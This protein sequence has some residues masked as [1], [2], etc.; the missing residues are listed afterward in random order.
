MKKGKGTK[1]SPTVAIQTLVDAFASYVLLANA[2]MEA[3]KGA[4]ARRYDKK[5]HKLWTTLRDDF[6]Q[7]GIDALARLLQDNRR[8]IRIMAAVHL[9]RHRTDDC[10]HLLK[11]EAGGRGLIA[12]QAEQTVKT[13]ERGEWQLG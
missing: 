1:L 9:M 11:A 7:E 10:L 13:W 12:F 8:E 6:K 4:K 2:A 5:Q 3:G